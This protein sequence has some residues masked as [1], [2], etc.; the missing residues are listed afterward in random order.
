MNLHDREQSPSNPLSD[1]RSH[2]IAYSVIPQAVDTVGL[3]FVK[4]VGQRPI[5]GETLHPLNFIGR[6]APHATVRIPDVIS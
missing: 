1:G 4:V 3:L 2:C 6:E 5:V